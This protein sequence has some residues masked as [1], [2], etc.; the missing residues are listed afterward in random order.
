VNSLRIAI[1]TFWLVLA[2]AAQAGPPFV[3]DDPEPPP[4]GGWDQFPV[5]LGAHTG[6]DGNECAIVRSELRVAERAALLP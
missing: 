3:T 2:S 4:V 1:S 5:H 6:Q